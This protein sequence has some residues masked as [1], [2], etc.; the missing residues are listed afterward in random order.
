MASQDEEDHHQSLHIVVFPWLA[1]GHLLPFLELSKRLSQRHSHR[2]S[3][4]STPRN[5][6]RIPKPPPHLAHL[7]SFVHLPLPT[8]PDLPPNAESTLDLDY[9]QVPYL[10]A[11]FDTL[12]TPFAQFLEI[13][14]PD[15]IIF[16]FV[17][18]WLPNIASKLNLPCIFF[19]IFN[20]S[21][22][23]F[24]G[25][26]SLAIDVVDPRNEPPHF[27]VKPNW[28][29]FE[30]N[31]AYRLHE[32]RRVFNSY[33]LNSDVPSDIFRYTSAVRGCDFMAIRTCNEFEGEF[34]KV[35]E[36][37]LKEKPVVLTGLLPPRHVVDMDQQ[38][39]L[40]L[41]IKQ[42]LDLR[43]P[44]SVV[45]VAFGSEVKLTQGEI[46]ELAHGLEMSEVPFFWVL[47]MKYSIQ[48]QLRVP[49]GF[50]E[51]V[52]GRGMVYI[53][54]APQQEILSHESIGGFVNQSGWSSVIESL[55]NGLP[56]AVLPMASTQGLVARLVVWRRVGVE[57]ESDERDGS[58]TR[59]AVAKAVRVVMVEEEGEVVREEAR[60][61]R[62]VFGDESLNDGYLDGFEL[63]LRERVRAFKR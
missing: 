22:T 26:P 31:M 19:N 16:D 35:C 42:W 14:K 53:E 46:E 21:T 2:I 57:I 6:Q 60:K 9:H 45:Y 25:P 30:S 11:A 52:R 41:S 62:E 54:W 59:E 29:P 50:E 33:Q 49:L 17:Q 34:V 56:M 1:F 28:I 32:I 40:P 47:K 36:E 37:I 15:L 27:T 3:F 43:E 7:I 20:A 51:R 63:F 10:K 4:V 55:A 38:N 13:S 48:T 24:A 44:R 61:A 8:N 12:A 23:A 5:L 18:H 39:K 58:F